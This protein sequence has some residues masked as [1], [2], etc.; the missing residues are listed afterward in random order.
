[1]FRTHS[2][3]SV[4]L[5]LAV[6]AGI[7]QMH[8]LPPYVML[9]VQ[10]SERSGQLVSSHERTLEKPQVAG[11]AAAIFCCCFLQSLHISNSI[12]SQTRPRPF[13]RLSFHTVIH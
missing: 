5:S 8:L 9:R 2:L 1:M 10:T 7:R 11:L 12:M 3:H 13:S 4:S 6:Y